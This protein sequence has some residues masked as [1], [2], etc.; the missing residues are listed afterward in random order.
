MRDVDRETI[1]A[2]CPACGYP[3]INPGLCAYCRPSIAL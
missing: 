3:T 1:T 2:I